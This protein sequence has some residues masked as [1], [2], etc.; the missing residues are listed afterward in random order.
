MALVDADVD[1]DVDVETWTGQN[2]T[3]YGVFG[4]V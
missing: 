4:V 3:E 2:R 1:V